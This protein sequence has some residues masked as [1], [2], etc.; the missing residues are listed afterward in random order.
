M[1][2]RIPGSRIVS[3]VIPAVLPDGFGDPPPADASH[4]N[5]TY[6]NATYEIPNLRIQLLQPVAN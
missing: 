2:A 3:S 4:P 1:M 5:A 6:E